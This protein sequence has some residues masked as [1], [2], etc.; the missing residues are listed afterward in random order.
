LRVR[1]LTEFDG[2]FEQLQTLGDIRFLDRV[3]SG[4][5]WAISEC[6]EDFDL[7]PGWQ[8]LRI[9]KF[10]VVQ[11]MPPM[12]LYFRIKDENEVIL[13]WIET[14]DADPEFLGDPDED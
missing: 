3:L 13:Y 6:A 14:T 10:D 9:V 4:V 12:R 5:T 7:V 2:F 8:T 1:T 11:D